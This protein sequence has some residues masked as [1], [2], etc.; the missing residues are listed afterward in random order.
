MGRLIDRYR[1]GLADVIGQDYA[2]SAARLLRRTIDRLVILLLVGV[3]LVVVMATTDVVH[4]DI[5]E[6]V[7][8]GAVVLAGAFF[9]IAAFQLNALALRIKTDLRAA[10]HTVKLPPDLRSPGLARAWATR[11]R[12]TL[13]AI[14]EAGK[15]QASG[16]RASRDA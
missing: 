9:F 16:K 5:G 10:G 14:V 12:L 1:A 11:E 6:L 2:R 7:A 13:N 8:A 3:A 4:T 15:Q